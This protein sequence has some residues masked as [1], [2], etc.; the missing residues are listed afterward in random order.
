MLHLQPPRRRLLA[1]RNG[2]QEEVKAAEGRAISLS[3]P[4]Q[5]WRPHTSPT[6]PYSAFL[7][8][9]THVTALLLA[10]PMLMVW[11]LGLHSQLNVPARFPHWHVKR[12]GPAT[13]PV[14]GITPAWT[15]FMWPLCFQGYL[16]H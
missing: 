11:G 7:P 10:S 12:P 8:E 15:V 4:I 6:H 14:I 9:E 13:V 3:L 1:Q 2:S 5:C 16:G